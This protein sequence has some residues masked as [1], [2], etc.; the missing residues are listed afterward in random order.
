MI[1]M[2]ENHFKPTIGFIGMG[3][4]GSHMTQRLIKAGYQLTVY[5]RMREKTREMGRQGALVALTPRDLSAGC[6][7]VMI[8][9]TDDRAQEEVMYGP[10][11]ALAGVH[12]G[13]IVIDLS[14]VSPDASRRLFQTAKE[15]IF[16]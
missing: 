10:D 1:S 3:H 7:V 14:T 4:M 8:S 5:D 13:S 15:K 16:L 12:D 9:V 2:E 6:Q 11:G